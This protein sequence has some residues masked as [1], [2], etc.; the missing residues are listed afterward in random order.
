MTLIMVA[1]LLSIAQIPLARATTPADDDVVGTPLLDPAK[2][3]DEDVAGRAAANAERF[4]DAPGEIDRQAR[5]D[6]RLRELRRA[7]AL[8]PGGV[9]PQGVPAWRP[10]GPTQAKYQAIA[11]PRVAPL[12]GSD[13]G[14]V[15]RVLQDPS[16]ADT[17]YVLTAGGGLWKTTT[18][19][20]T[21]PRW[22]AK[23]DAL[24]STSGGGLALGRVAGTLFLGLG[25][26]FFAGIPALGGLMVK[27][28]DGGD[29]WSS[30][31]SLE[32]ASTVRDVQVDGSA[33][34]DVVL[35][36]TDGGLFRSADAGQ[37]YALVR[38]G[39]ALYPADRGY[40]SLARTSAGWLAT[41]GNGSI[42]R[43]SDLGATWTEE[44]NAL[45]GAGRVTLAVAAPGDAVVYAF[46]AN[47]HSFAQLDLF[48][49]ADGG[50]TWTAL[51]LGSKAPVNPTPFVADMNLMGG[52]AYYGQMLLVDPADASRGTVYIGG[53]LATAK[54]SDGGATWTL[55]SQGLPEL[56]LSL[57]YVHADHHTASAIVLR[58]LPAIVFGTDGGIFLSTDGGASFRD[59]KNEGIDSFLAQNVMSSSR[60]K[61]DVVLSM[62]DTGTR[63]RQGATS[64]FNV[65]T[66]GDGEGIGWSQAN[67]AT[68]LTSMQFGFIFRLSG[69]LPDL[70]SLLKSP[71]PV[72]SYVSPPLRV[73]DGWGFFTPI[74]TPDA[75]VD[76]SGLIFFTATRRRVFVTFDGA[77]SPRSWF[78][79]A[80]AGGRLPPWFVIRDT[81]HHIGLDADPAFNRVAVGGNFGHVAFTLDGGVT[82]TATPSLFVLVPGFKNAISSTAWTAAGTLYV[83]SES[84]FT[85]AIHVV[86]TA[87][88]G[89]SWQQAD[90][91]LPDEPVFHLLLDPRDPTG[92]SIYAATNLGVYRT[93]DGG[94]S[95]FRFGAGLPMVAV[96]GLWAA[97]DGSLLRAASYGRGGWE[98]N[99]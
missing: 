33:A 41:G 6:G 5:L 15:R 90:F 14:R 32:G 56:D 80:R 86:K 98:I 95:W 30:P 38:P 52:Q 68:T 71:T 21:S 26:P 89:R 44:A 43:S 81:A 63:V 37:S 20:Q 45:P 34:A 31:V 75:G 85:G 78:V 7:A 12:K 61:Q 55:V 11:L 13:S 58:G 23:T 76:P 17:V 2:G 36:A 92:N 42:V 64:V 18:F 83:A 72:G 16:D 66:P 96:Q 53:Q 87:D 73:G 8:L 99:P 91:G 88:A 19:G 84:A 60:N 47:T 79:L 9:A 93:G 40:W 27:S 69:L 50:L 59:D 24:V 25:D 65:I 29:N 28:S 70:F 77:Q 10:L 35:V 39:P 4:A 82:W 97:A 3:A 74:A 57:P 49:S 67:D 48:R 22:T 94:Q 54:S 62:Q 51:G 1:A 46:A